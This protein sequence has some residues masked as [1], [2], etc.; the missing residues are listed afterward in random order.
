[1]ET[2]R[3]AARGA[4]P[5]AS[6]AKRVAVLGGGPSG[7]TTVKACLEEGHIPVCFEQDE[8]IGG[9]WRFTEKEGH[10]CGVGPKLHVS[11]GANPP[12]APAPHSSVYRSTVINS[13]KEFNCFSDFPIP[14]EMPPFL[15]HEQ[16]MDYFRSYAAHFE[17]ERHVRL[18]RRVVAVEALEGGAGYDVT[19]EDGGERRGVDRETERFDAV[20]VCTGHHWDPNVPAPWPGQDKFQGRVMHS[21]SYKDAVGF[22]GKRVVVVGVGNSGVDIAVELSHVAKHVSLSTRSGAW[23]AHRMGFGKPIDHIGNNRLI[24]MLPRAAL[25]AVGTAIHD[26]VNGDVDKFGLTPKHGFLAAHPTINDHLIPRVG[27]SPAR[28]PRPQSLSHS[29]LCDTVIQ[30]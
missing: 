21:H 26:M 30:Q 15:H 14:D 29:H 19:T 24:N 17:L 23:I 1:M 12:L 5:S 8:D 7:L 22:D 6:T 3:G 13:S 10:R 27:A 2:A 11:E 16:L 20:A 28:R 18:R 25:A 4:A 9:L